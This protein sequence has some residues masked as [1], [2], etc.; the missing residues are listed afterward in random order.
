MIL[1]GIDDATETEVI[2]VRIEDVIEETEVIPVKI[3][4]VI[5]ETEVILEKIEDVT[6][7][8]V[9]LEN[10]EEDTEAILKT[11][12]VIPLV[13]NSTLSLFCFHKTTPFEYPHRK[14]QT[15]HTTN[16]LLLLSLGLLLII[17]SLV[18][19][20]GLSIIASLIVP[21]LL[22]PSTLFNRKHT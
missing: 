13:I 22:Q 7:T 18:L 5:E 11:I 1:E 15:N 9:I 16:N 8:E 19:K 2:L 6:E 21:F 4:D 17:S 20:R 12:E 3:D 14:Q 10:I